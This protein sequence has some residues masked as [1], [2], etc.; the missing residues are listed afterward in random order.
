M[1]GYN[2][3]YNKYDKLVRT[4]YLH[5]LFSI[6]SIDAGFIKLDHNIIY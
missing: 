6:L 1:S 2:L 3:F 4:I 5:I